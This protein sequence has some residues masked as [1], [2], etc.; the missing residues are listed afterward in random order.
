MIAFGDRV[1]LDAGKLEAGKEL[2]FT[3]DK[4]AVR[5]V[6][7][8][9]DTKI[10]GDT[11]LY[12]AVY[13]G[14]TLTA[15][16]PSGKRAVIV[17]TDGRDER[18]N[19]QH[20]PVPN[21]GSLTSPD[22]P[23]NEATRQS[24]P[25]FTIGLGNNLDARYLSRLALRTGGQ[26]QE[27]P[28]PEELTALFQKVLDQ[29]KQQYVLSYNTGLDE[30]GS[31]HSLMVR[32]RAPQGQAFDEVKFWLGPEV[33]PT[34][35]VV[36]MAPAANP[37]AQEPTPTPEPTAAGFIERIRNNVQD[38][39]EDKPGLAAAIGGGALLLIVLIVVLVV[40]LARGRRAKAAE[41]GLPE[42]E[43]PFVPPV[44]PG[45]SPAP[46]AVRPAAAP[47]AVS[48][49]IGWDDAASPGW[50]TPG[51]G[52]PAAAPIWGQP[53][54]PAGGGFAQVPPPPE[55]T[56]VIERAPRHLAMLVN[57]SRPDQ[58]HDLKD[59]MNVGR[60]TDNQ[61]VIDH[62]TVSRHHAWIKED[63]GEFLVFD[64]GS[65]N[66]TF[67]NDQQIDAPRP[68]QNGDLVRFGEVEFVFTKVF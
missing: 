8:L 64:I 19:A 20:T 37:R 58:K 17:M 65:G 33:S 59:T 2:G 40:V 48:E 53:A 13:K 1:D 22:D 35:A 47:P 9:L 3:T 12:D 44:A 56:R 42:P 16:E 62:P 36:A 45:P 52:Q 51:V 30:D 38:T 55:G 23:I 24:I 66:G 57:K 15:R 6:I 34:A 26:Y 7:D 10:G 5:N 4:N 18:D 14:L 41:I 63:K 46:G 31:F 43:V 67:V 21:A 11:P 27:T 29:L 25:V 61:V 28:N 32:V 50:G 60:A 39:V 49:T 54:A 68:L